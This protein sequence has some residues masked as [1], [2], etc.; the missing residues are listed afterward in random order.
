MKA[1]E[2]V[3]KQAFWGSFA[4]LQMNSS[5]HTFKAVIRKNV[6]YIPY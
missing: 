4:W 5:K 6:G 1:N 2:N 3:G